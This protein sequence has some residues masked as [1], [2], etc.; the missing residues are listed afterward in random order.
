MNS[1]S[2][3]QILDDAVCISCDILCIYLL[4]QR[5]SDKQR[6]QTEVELLRIEEKYKDVEQKLKH[7]TTSLNKANMTLNVYKIV[8]KEQ[9]QQIHQLNVSILFLTFCLF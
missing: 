7:K 5:L 8:L 1:A 9:Q 3:I 6:K 2:Q 4:F